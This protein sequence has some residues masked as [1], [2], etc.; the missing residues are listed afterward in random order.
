MQKADHPDF[1]SE[2]HDGGGKHRRG[3]GVRCRSNERRGSGSLSEKV[4]RLF[5][6]SRPSPCQMVV[7]LLCARQS[8]WDPC[9]DQIID[10]CLRFFQ[11]PWNSVQQHEYRSATCASHSCL[12]LPCCSSDTSPAPAARASSRGRC[13][14]RLSFT[15]SPLEAPKRFIRDHELK[16]YN[17]CSCSF[18]WPPGLPY[19]T[20]HVQPTLP[21]P[22]RI[23]AALFLEGC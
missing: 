18:F 19:C 10:A 23:D 20:L 15:F 7:A 4:T 12:P 6:C 13:C 16:R 17:H 11:E 2:R 5:T 8:L 3:R 22:G 9:S 14:N 21:S 1:G